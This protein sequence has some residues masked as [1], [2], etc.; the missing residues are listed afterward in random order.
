M[1]ISF[2]FLKIG[3]LLCILLTQPAV[4]Q[5]FEFDSIRYEDTLNVVGPLPN[6]LFPIV[7]GVSVDQ[8]VAGYT[9]V[10]QLT[11]SDKHIQFKS[12]YPFCLGS[13]SKGIAIIKSGKIDGYL[14]LERISLARFTHQKK[15]V[16]YI[17]S[18]NNNTNFLPA[19][20]RENSNLPLTLY[21][22]NQGEYIKQYIMYGEHIVLYEGLIKSSMDIFTKQILLDYI[23]RSVNELNEVNTPTF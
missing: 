23:A 14:L 4:S 15:L 17:K 10:Y 11:V 5:S 3:G 7:E 19:S 16:D 6:C 12:K 2:L 21:E 20:I 18:Q 9:D 22:S 13:H 1:R 8:F